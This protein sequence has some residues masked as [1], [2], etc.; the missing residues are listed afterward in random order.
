MTFTEAF[1]DLDSREEKEFYHSLSFPNFQKIVLNN[2]KFHRFEAFDRFFSALSDTEDTLKH[3][4][5][6]RL[7]SLVSANCFKELLLS[8]SQSLETLVLSGVHKNILSRKH[9]KKVMIAISKLQ[10]L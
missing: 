7:N 2:C 1:F 3:L 4:E 9:H 10:C 8:Q 5:I 6:N